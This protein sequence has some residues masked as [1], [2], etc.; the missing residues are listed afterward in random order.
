MA[1]EC[2]RKPKR[3]AQKG[4][5]FAREMKMT[6]PSRK[7]SREVS[8]M[9]ILSCVNGRDYVPLTMDVRISER[10]EIVMPDLG[11]GYYLG[12]MALSDMN[13]VAPGLAFSFDM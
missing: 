2:G 7:C 10:S 13:Y 6:W 3:R 5:S 4:K 1:T 11:P 12:T 9:F 8:I